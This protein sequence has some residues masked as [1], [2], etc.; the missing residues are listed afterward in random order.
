MSADYVAK[1]HRIRALP[2]ALL[3]KVRQHKSAAYLSISQQHTSA[4]VSSIPQHTSAAYLSL[5]Q[6]HTSAYVS[7][8]RRIRALPAALLEKVPAL[9][10]VYTY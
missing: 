5:R 6:Q 3:E 8:I 4:Y 10:P 1:L 7:S 9:V 2:A